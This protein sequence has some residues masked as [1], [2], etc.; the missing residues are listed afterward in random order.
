MCQLRLP[1]EEMTPEVI[2]DPS[3]LSDCVTLELSE[4]GGHVGFVEGGTPL[5]PK[6]YLPKRIMAFLQECIDD[7]ERSQPV[8]PGL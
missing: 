1:R 2:P 8:M 6:F 7:S 5:R 3:L 4:A